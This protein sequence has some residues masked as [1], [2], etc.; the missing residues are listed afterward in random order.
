MRN[1]LN[2]TLN[3]NIL[4]G[5]VLAL[6][7]IL[8][9]L[10]TL[11]IYLNFLGAELYGLWIALSV[12]IAISQIG[13]LGITSAITKFVAGS[14]A[15][16]DKTK[17]T[18]YVS[19][20]TV[21]LA[22]PSIVILFASYFLKT[23]IIKLLDINQLYIEDSIILIP[24]TG[25]LSIITLYNSLLLGILMGL[26]KV[27]FANYT[28]LIAK[29]I[30]IVVSIVFI[31]LEFGIWSLFYG[32]SIAYLFSLIITYHNL[33]YVHKIKLFDIKGINKKRV[34]E[35]SVFGGNLVGSKL[36]S[37]LMDPLNKIVISRYIGLSY[38]TYYEI[39]LK[40]AFNIRNVF[41]MGFRAIMPKISELEMTTNH[42]LTEI[43]IIYKKGLKLLTLFALPLFIFC[44]AAAE[45]ILNLWLGSSHDI[46][47]LIGFRIFLVAYLINL[48]AVPAYYILMGL[49]KV[50][51]IL[52]AAILRSLLH[53]IIVL[54]I[55]LNFGTIEFTQIIYIHA[56]SM[57]IAAIFILYVYKK[58]FNKK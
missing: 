34:R 21:F 9:L 5:S 13:D 54:L 15:K 35:L 16:N 3:K 43:R 52:K 29:I 31:F 41:E 33:T 28:S 22:V 1:L 11:P 44:F 38:V 24:L 55:V 58:V 17:I 47:I 51:Y 26:Q 32:I 49:N 27:S 36:V 45:F 42:Y 2:S 18:A 37:L 8:A 7:N 53:S 25:V 46:S 30:Q 40:G 23:G 4:S 14:Y 12:I 39:S 50:R 56:I 6:T 57:A 19:T 10:I 48:Y 20:A